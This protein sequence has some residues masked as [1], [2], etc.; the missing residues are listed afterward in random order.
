MKEADFNVSQVEGKVVAFGVEVIWTWWSFIMLV[1]NLMFGLLCLPTYN[2]I[3][4][5]IDSKP[6]GL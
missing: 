3:L 1:V 4:R 6:T 5:Y 2:I